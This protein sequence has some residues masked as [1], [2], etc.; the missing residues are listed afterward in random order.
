M[1]PP[2]TQPAPQAEGGTSTSG[3]QLNALESPRAAEAH[4]TPAESNCAQEISSNG[5]AMSDNPNC[6]TPTANSSSRSVA[7]G[8]MVAPGKHGL[9][10]Q[11]PPDAK[12]QKALSKDS[13]AAMAAIAATARLPS[14]VMELVHLHFS[15][16]VTNMT[17]SFFV[18]LAGNW[19]Y[20]R[21]LLS[22]L[23][24]SIH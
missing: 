7:A 23:E 21:A 4:S 22:Q 5:I 14:Q 11:E 13:L 8:S 15:C 24:A 1:V 2:S 6:S 17:A 19:T 16:N 10:Q 20:S 18:E 12:R 3:A 9:E